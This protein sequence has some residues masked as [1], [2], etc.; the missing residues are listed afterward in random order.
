MKPTIY[1]IWLEI[2]NQEIHFLDTVVYKT[3]SGKPET[4]SNGKNPIDRL[5]YILNENTLSLWNEAYHFH[6]LYVFATW[7]VSS[8]FEVEGDVKIIYYFFVAC[9]YFSSVPFK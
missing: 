8:I 7:L 9:Y 3:K 6:K 2:S 4:S 1:K 5:I